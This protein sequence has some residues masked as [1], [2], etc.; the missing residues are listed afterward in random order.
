MATAWADALLR[1]SVQGG[2]AILIVYSLLRLS[3]RIPARVR[4]WVWRLVLVKLFATLLLPIPIAKGLPALGAG[5]EAQP[6]L[7]TLVACLLAVCAVLVAVA[8]IR[9]LFMVKGLVAG[10]NPSGPAT[11]EAARLAG[12]LGIR[13][14]PRVLESGAASTPML[15]RGAILLPVGFAAEK[16]ER[17]LRMTLAHE[18]AHYRN[19]DLA[20]NWLPT[21]ARALF[22]FHPLVHLALREL[23]GAEEAYCDELAIQATGATP[24][25][26]GAMLIEI[27]ATMPGESYAAVA[28]AS[29]RNLL[30]R[31]ILDLV[32]GGLRPSPV[33]SWSVLGAALVL[34]PGYRFVPSQSVPERSLFG[35]A[36]AISP[37]APMAKP[38]NDLSAGISLKDHSNRRKTQ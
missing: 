20:W 27:C 3:R 34:L 10:A 9:D 24:E 32:S 19:R 4:V 6:L 36:R 31:R 8:V 12:I 1:T 5:P 7:P 30:R 17:A 37:A 28:M 15:V 18:L 16:G 33:L 21:I 26:Y 35:P 11:E 29:P 23:A 2:L 25:D 14:V 22:F 13:S 38:V